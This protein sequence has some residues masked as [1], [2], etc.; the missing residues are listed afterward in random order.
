MKEAGDDMKNKNAEFLACSKRTVSILLTILMVVLFAGCQAQTAAT[1]PTP[2]NEA[3]AT[4]AATTEPTPTPTA[5]P[6]AETPEPTATAAA[7]SAAASMN[8]NDILDII[9]NLPNGSAGISLKQASAAAKLLDWAQGTDLDEEGVAE[10]IS[11]YMDGLSNPTAAGTF[12]VNFEL[13]SGLPQKIID[14]DASTV[15]MVS[16]AGYTLGYASYSQAKWDT[17]LAAFKD[18]LPNMYSSYADMV[19][20][21][22]ETGWALFDYWDMLKGDEAKQWLIDHEGYTAA[23]AQTYVDNMSESEYVKKNT[24]TRLRAVDMSDVSIKMM[25][26]AD[27]TSVDDATT[28]SLT[29]G[30]F[31]TLYAANPDNV[32]NSYFYFVTVGSG[33]S[34]KVEQVYWP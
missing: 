18:C 24:N 9:A 31:M 4:A 34:T 26:H 7:T 19:S 8:L 16:D 13:I 6:A 22:P 29:Y 25:Y 15:G 33:S 30:E 27:G 12:T 10:K 28:V 11:T 20:F 23:N 14:G 3:T 1:E 21:D 17:F 5:T 2:E 32:L